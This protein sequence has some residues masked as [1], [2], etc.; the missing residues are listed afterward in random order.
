MFGQKAPSPFY[1]RSAWLQNI[2]LKQERFLAF[3]K[4]I[5]SDCKYLLNLTSYR[6]HELSADIL[7]LIAI[8][9]SIN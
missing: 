1:I 8:L 6:A 5:R 3:Y 7:L 9:Y 4:Y 2:T